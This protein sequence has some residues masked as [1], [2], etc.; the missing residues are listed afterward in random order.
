MNSNVSGQGDEDDVQKNPLQFS[1]IN[2]EFCGSQV[3][4]VN[5]LQLSTDLIWTMD[6]PI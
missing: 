6:Y 4:L 3:S 1:T 2:S 5:Q